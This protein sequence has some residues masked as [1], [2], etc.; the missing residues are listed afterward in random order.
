MRFALTADQQMVADAVRALATGPLAAAAAAIDREGQVPPVVAKQL[1]ELGAWGLTV[2]ERAGGLGLDEQLAV[3]CLTALAAADAG[4]AQ[5]V[6]ERDAATAILAEHGQRALAAQLARAQAVLGVAVTQSTPHVTAH[7]QP[8]GSWQLEGMCPWV[9]GGSDEAWGLVA[10]KT[11]A[12]DRLF[13]TAI[14]SG[15]RQ[16]IG[17]QLGL[18]GA[19]AS[20]WIFAGAAANPVG[21]GETLATFRALLA[22]R[23]AAVAVGVGRSALQAAA[24]YAAQREQFG[25]A[26]ATLQPVQWHLADSATALDAAELLVQ[27]AAWL[28]APPC[29]GLAAAAHAA[30][31]KAC[32]AAVAVADKA[33]QVHGG[34]GYT[35]D[36]SVERAYRD[37]HVLSAL[38]GEV[39]LHKVL[40]AR[41][42]AV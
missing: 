1:S 29:K 4:V 12:G 42:L 14:H 35:R 31:A 40:A 24:R 38:N 28:A 16:P 10:A 25:K 13:L 20:A 17:E 5:A 32:E 7:T 19:A 41:R 9:L 37:A 21:D 27:R 11:D 23:T 15:Q 26:I 6:A 34:Y 22:L 8:D 39:P 18:R 36:F 30:K 33:I 3:A 2:A